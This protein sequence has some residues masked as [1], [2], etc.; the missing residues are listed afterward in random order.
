[1]R[2]TL[3]ML[4][5]V[6]MSFAAVGAKPPEGH[7][8]KLDVLAAFGKSLPEKHPYLLYGKGGAGEFRRR[9]GRKDLPVMSALR[10]SIVARADELMP[11]APFPRTIV[12]KRMLTDIGSRSHLLAAAYLAT[13]D[14][15]YARRCIAE[16]L[17]AADYVD[18]NP[19]H[20][21]DSAMVGLGVALGYDAC[22][23]VMSV[24]ERKK[25]S[26]A[27]A[28]KCIA[29][30][31]G[32]W[33]WDSKINWSQVCGCG[34]AAAALAIARDEGRLESS[35]QVV[36]DCCRAAK[37]GATAYAPFGV[38][39]EGPAY[40]SYGTD[41]YVL[42]MDM[43]DKTCGVDFGLFDMPG[44]SLTGAFIDAITAP[45]GEYFDFSDRNAAA[46][47]FYRGVEWSMFWLGARSGHPEWYA[48]EN[49]KL[50]K[51]ARTKM[52]G[53]SWP[54]AFAMWWRPGESGRTPLD[55]ARYFHHDE[56]PVGLI[57]D[58]SHWVAVKGGRASFSHGHMD[59]GSFV[60]ETFGA[61]WA[62]RWVCDG[63]T[64]NY[65]T[66]ET[67]WIDVWNMAQSS[68]RWSVFRYS[69]RAH[70]VF[71]IDDEQPK[72]DAAVKLTKLDDASFA[73]DT[74]GLY[75]AYVGTAERTFRL[76]GGAFTVADSFWGVCG[77]HTYRWAFQ[78]RTE[79]SV[80]NGGVLLNSNGRRM[81]VYSSMP[82]SW[83]VERNPRGG[84][85]CDTANAGFSR[86]VFTAPLVDGAYEFTFV[87][88]TE[89]RSEQKSGFWSWLTGLFQ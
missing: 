2:V 30:S 9:L 57:G 25:V 6:V 55:G 7:P 61:G 8:C 41:Y 53:V 16:M 20:F 23:D 60:Y 77:D 45:S 70:S 26:E 74:A 33:F 17:A 21:L 52:C 31:A 62:V 59:A 11:K 19:S 72:V 83:S 80:V 27:L 46:D 43:L 42:L 39:P 37:A 54:I 81:L 47:G 36:A 14:G 12:G 87:E 68:S 85:S 5:G 28:E 76:S 1:M 69:E 89:A 22:W 13:E 51:C 32:H 10:A 38:Y 40:W 84:L 66:L 79:A 49:E 44:V 88:G 24:D 56:Q 48:Y 73:A 86:V 64:E 18:W 71:T 82:G 75:P 63:G 78:T 29:A 58:S 15:K 4:A 65:N 3:L 34:V 35:A 67:A 50:E